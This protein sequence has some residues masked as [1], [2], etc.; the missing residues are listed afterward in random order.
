MSRGAP[1]GMMGESDW[2]GIPK[3][4]A[5]SQQVF[6]VELVEGKEVYV[7]SSKFLSSARD[8]CPHQTR[9]FTSGRL[10]TRLLQSRAMARPEYFVMSR[11]DS[12]EPRLT[13]RPEA[14]GQPLLRP[15]NLVEKREVAA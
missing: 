6:R 5:Y 12:A 7:E 14:G 2:N 10:R 4:F 1:R 8:D 15:L 3:G 13:K 11:S 9:L